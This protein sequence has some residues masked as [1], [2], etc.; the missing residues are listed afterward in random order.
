M[1]GFCHPVRLARQALRGFMAIPQLISTILTTLRVLKLTL[2]R[3]KQKRDLTK[4]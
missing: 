2:I 4:N 1:A 3:I